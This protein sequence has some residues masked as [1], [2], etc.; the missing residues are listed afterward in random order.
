M[1]FY[2]IP[3]NP[4]IT[5]PLAIL[6]AGG[7]TASAIKGGLCH[8][9]LASTVTTGGIT[10]RIPLLVWLKQVPQACV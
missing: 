7:G 1:G 2:C 9:R 3:I 4:I 10:A 8:W 5:G 6:I